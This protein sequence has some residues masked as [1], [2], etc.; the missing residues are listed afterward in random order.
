VRRRAGVPI[1]VLTAVA[2][3]WP[4]PAHGQ[5]GVSLLGLGRPES[6]TDARIRGMGG[7]GVVAHGRN[8]SLWNPAALADVASPGVLLT[9]STESRTVRGDRARGDLRGTRFPVGQLVYPVGERWAVAAGWGG[10]LDQDW[11]LSFRDSLALGD[12]T[13]PFTENR[14]SDGGVV[15]LRGTV[16][17][18]AADALHLGLGL[19]RYV[20]D[21]IR[22]VSRR[23]D[24]PAAGL[25]SYRDRARW[26]YRAWGLA[27]GLAFVPD[28]DIRLGAT[29]AWTSE[30][31]AR[32]D[33]VAQTARFPMP[34]RADVG[35][36]WQLTPELLWVA[37]AG[38]AGWSRTG[39]ALP[40][41]ARN[42]W[43]LGTGIEY[44]FA[45]SEATT[46]RI[47]AGYR[48]AD[49]PFQDGGGTGGEH[50]WTAGAGGA[51][52]GGLVGLDLAFEWGRRGD[53]ARL[54]VEE[55]FRRISLSLAVHQRGR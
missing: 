11:L 45:R 24:D 34:L 29:L 52:A 38:F 30:L 37:Y 13:I 49:L 20:G 16:A 54:G 1:A 21:V 4:A 41:G 22:E 9:T 12:D 43:A 26:T 35:G 2:A 17:W 47:R 10:F 31:E 32:R 51:F 18:Q 36:S 48:R 33:S 27:L 19:D 50:A 40:G 53:A 39:R 5:A 55:S 44:A 3:A 15:R 28:P 46:Y 6:P 8:L 42:T 7:A 25:L 14:S 23:F